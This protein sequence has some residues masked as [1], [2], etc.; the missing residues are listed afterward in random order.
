MSFRPV[1]QEIVEAITNDKWQ[2]TRAKIERACEDAYNLG[3]QRLLER[4][5]AEAESDPEPAACSHS[6]I[7]ARCGCGLVRLL[8]PDGSPGRCT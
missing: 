7:G 3:A 5:S 4:L 2:E 6:V 8:E 1:A